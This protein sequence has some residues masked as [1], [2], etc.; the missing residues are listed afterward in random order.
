MLIYIY[1]FLLTSI[2][3]INIY[4]YFVCPGT[5]GDMVLREGLVNV[6]YYIYTY[7]Y[8]IKDFLI[9]IY[10]EHQFSTE[11]IVFKERIY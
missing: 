7:V 8:C 10:A 9:D 2:P 6:E 4:S 1:C 3:S 5:R 11:C